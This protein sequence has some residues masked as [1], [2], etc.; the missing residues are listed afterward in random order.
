MTT[1]GLMC[2][3]MAHEINQPLNI[4]QVCADYFIKMLNR[5]HA[6]PTDDLLSMTNDIIVNGRRIS[7]TINHV[8]DFT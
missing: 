2:A 1:L 5:K 4:I 6:I 7:E 8:K 3:G